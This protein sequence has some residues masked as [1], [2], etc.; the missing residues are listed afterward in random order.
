MKPILISGATG[1]GTTSLAS[2]ISNKFGIQYLVGTDAIR[3][4]ARQIIKPEVNPYLHKSSYLA[5]KST[6]YD[7]KPEEIKREKTVRG[8]KIQSL[9]VKGCIEGVVSR[10]MKEGL[11]FIVEGINLL[12]GDYNPLLEE[13][14]INQVLID[15][16][17]EKVHLDRIRLRTLKNPSRGNQYEENFREIRWLRDYLARKAKENHIPIIDNSGSIESALAECLPITG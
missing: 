16:A 7:L 8:F 3:E 14:S 1:V 10:Y 11:L 12:P 9:A 5:G 17:S 4:A 15:L 2:A 6:N 13:G